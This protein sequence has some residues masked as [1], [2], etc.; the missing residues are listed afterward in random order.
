MRK[1]GLQMAVTTV[2][3]IILAIAVL[4]ILIIFMNSQTGFFSKWLKDEQGKSNVDF[5]VSVCNNLVARKSVYSY[6]CDEKEIVLG[7]KGEVDDEGNVVENVLKM[8]CDASR[9]E[10]WSGGRIKELDCSGVC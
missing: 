5:I 8:T 3:M 4:T 10:S 2:I 9:G 7:G 6:C 1:K